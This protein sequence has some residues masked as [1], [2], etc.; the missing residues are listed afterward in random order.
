VS[1]HTANADFSVDQVA[2]LWLTLEAPFNN[3]ITVQRYTANGS[4][5]AFSLGGSGVVNATNVFINGVYQNKDT[6]SINTNVLTFGEAPPSGAI[7]EIIVGS[8]SPVTA[9]VPDLSIST[10]KIADGAITTAKIANG[11]V[12]TADLADGAVTSAK[13]ADGVVTPGKLSTGGPTWDTSGIVTAMGGLN[14]IIQALPNDANGIGSFSSFAKNALNAIVG[15]LQMYCS[16]G[17]AVLNSAYNLPML[18]LTNN[19]ERMRISADGNVGI[20][21]SSPTAK[22]DVVGNDSTGNGVVVKVVNNNASASSSSQ[23]LAVNGNGVSVQLQTY[24]N[25]ALVNCTSNHNLE[26]RTNNQPRL[27]ITNT[28]GTDTQGNPITNCPTTA[29]AWAWVTGLVN[30]NGAAQ[31][32][33]GY[34][35][36]SIIRGATAGLYTIT[37]TSGT[38]TGSVVLASVAGTNNSGGRIF[39]YS[40]NTCVVQMYVGVTSTDFGFNMVYFSN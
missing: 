4:Q 35:V 21:T 2:G 37:L 24:N 31:A 36:A 1:A 11:A 38:F 8:I 10:A 17:A 22:L 12:I 33:T 29:K 27:V 14:P 23:L 9:V 30:T 5:V 26:L 15:Q 18:F 19:A 25:F 16:T 40:G 20:G 13:I 28:G 7:V 39:S 34:N 32:F 6:Y 3:S